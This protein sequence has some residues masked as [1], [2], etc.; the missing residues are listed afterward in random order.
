MRIMVIDYGSATL[1]HK[2]FS[3][4]QGG[5]QLVVGGTVEISRGYR[6]AVTQALKTLPQAPDAI[7]HRVVHGGNRAPEVLR[8]GLLRR[9][10]LPST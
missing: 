10:H 4:H 2:L 9:R 7:A 5:I 6:A 8:V 1:K 3:T